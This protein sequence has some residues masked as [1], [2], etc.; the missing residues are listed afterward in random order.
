MHGFILV[1]PWHRVRA[2]LAALAELE[3][4]MPHLMALLDDKV[5]RFN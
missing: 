2:V 4:E 1:G 5:I 3:S